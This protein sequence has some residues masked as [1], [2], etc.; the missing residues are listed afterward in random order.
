MSKICRRCNSVILT[1]ETCGL[2]GEAHAY[3]VYRPQEVPG[4]KQQRLSTPHH[5]SRG[6]PCAKPTPTSI[7]ASG[8]LTEIKRFCGKYSFPPTAFGRRFF[9][10]GNLVERLQNGA[11]PRNDTMEGIRKAM[12]DYEQNV[13][14]LYA[15]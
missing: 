6:L 2:C 11:V 15:A 12:R 5:R 8:L 3:I 4:V 7:A 9:N 14:R 13:D 10:D 1:P